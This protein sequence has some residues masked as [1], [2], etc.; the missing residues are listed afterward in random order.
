[1]FNGLDKSFVSKSPP[2][3]SPALF[4]IVGSISRL[5]EREK[6]LHTILILVLTKVLGHSL[7]ILNDKFLK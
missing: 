6:Q 4:A 2:A 7:R 3:I 5:R 1:V